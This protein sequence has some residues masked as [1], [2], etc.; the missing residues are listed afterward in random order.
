MQDYRRAVAHSK[1][2]LK[3]EL[4]STKST[5]EQREAAREELRAKSLARDQRNNTSLIADQRI[6]E[7][8]IR[9][10]E[11]FEA[12]VQSHIE[13][14]NVQKRE[15]SQRCCHKV[16]QVLSQGTRHREEQERVELERAGQL[17]EKMTK[18]KNALEKY[19]KAKRKAS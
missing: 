16:E 18:R 3:E 7:E 10:L 2:R 6:N 5:F 11:S 4:K 13:K 15:R 19:E 1:R 8:T 9:T 14:A 12:R 17:L